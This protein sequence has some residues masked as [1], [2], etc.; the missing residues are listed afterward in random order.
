MRYF[1]KTHDNSSTACFHCSL[2]VNISDASG[3]EHISIGKVLSRH[4]ANGQLGKDNL[5]A[6][7]VNLLQ[8]L[9]E[10][11]PLGVDNGL[12]KIVKNLDNFFRN[13]RARF[14]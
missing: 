10:N 12:K 11:I 4:I 8:F 13:L 14:V 9:I 7:S 3:A 2:Q 1:Q 6:G 5:G